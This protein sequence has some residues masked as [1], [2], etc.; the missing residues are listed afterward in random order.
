MQ[1]NQSGMREYAIKTFGIDMRQIT[2]INIGLTEEES[3][4]LLKIRESQRIAGFVSVRLPIENFEIDVELSNE[5]CS[6]GWN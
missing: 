3:Q 2:G 4:L 6:H 5:C 1:S